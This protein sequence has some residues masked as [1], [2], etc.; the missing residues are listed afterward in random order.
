MVSSGWFVPDDYLFLL[1][2]RLLTVQE[3]ATLSRRELQ[4]VD[5]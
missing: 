4:Q 1:S 2:S 3:L 5:P